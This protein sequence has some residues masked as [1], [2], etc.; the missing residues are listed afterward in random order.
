MYMMRK[1]GEDLE[2]KKTTEQQIITWWSASGGVGKTTLAVIQAYLLAKE[3][4]E[5]VALLD[6]NE[7]TPCCS[8]YLGI[9]QRDPAPVFGAVEKNE[10]SSSFIE[11]NMVGHPELSN[12][13]VF[14]GV[15]LERSE[16]FKVKHYTAIIDSLLSYPYIIIDTNPGV[17]FA[18]CFAALKK[19]TAVN[20]VIGPACKSVYY[21]KKMIDFVVSKWEIPRNNFK[22]NLNKMC[23]GGVDPGTVK[24]SFKDTEV[25]GVFKYNPE[26]VEAFNSGKPFT[27]G[28]E[29][30]VEEL[31]VQIERKKD[32][33]SFF[34]RKRGEPVGAD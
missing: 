19:A 16:S 32:I 7:V 2:N 17:F 33:F 11:S 22:L 23:P 26:I 12:L 13:K 21:T 15:P 30:L 25:A 14:T 24:K 27:K 3:T 34:R 31:G 4:K 9:E 18:S 29:S 1:R 6:F 28:F 20:V 8:W 5:K 10:L